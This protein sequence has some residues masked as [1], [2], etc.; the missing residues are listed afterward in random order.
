MIPWKLKI[1]GFLSYAEAVE[2]DFSSFDLACISGSNGAGKSSLLDA[3]T[4][5]LFGEARGKTDDLIN[6]R[7][8]KAEVEFIFDY[9]N[10]RYRVLRTRQRGKTDDQ[11]V[12]PGQAR[13]RAGAGKLPADRRPRP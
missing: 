8:S 2:L 7:C 11:P 5:V 13:H 9:E 12:Y 6:T 10:Q 4:W 3:I 1:N